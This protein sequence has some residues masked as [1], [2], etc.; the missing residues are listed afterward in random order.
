MKNTILRLILALASISCLFCSITSCAVRHRAGPAVP[1]GKSGS[2]MPPSRVDE[3]YRDYHRLELKAV[4][5]FNPPTPKDIVNNEVRNF[6]V[7]EHLEI[8]SIFGDKK[9]MHKG[10]VDAQDHFTAEFF[11]KE[12]PLKVKKLREVRFFMPGYKPRTFRDV[13]ISNSTIDLGTVSFEKDVSYVPRKEEYILA[14][15]AMLTFDPKVEPAYVCD[16]EHYGVPVKLYN[17]DKLDIEVEFDGKITHHPG[18][19]SNK[20]PS[21][22]GEPLIPV[23]ELAYLGFNYPVDRNPDK[24]GVIKRVRFSCPGYR[25]VVFRDVRI[26]LPH[27]VDFGVVKLVKK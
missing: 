1:A 9:T 10:F 15:R 8:Y 26:D 17:I 21:K 24:V 20:L 2:P 3:L 12:D 19:V 22:P 27:K 7:Y 25:D 16:N 11:V 14:I 6:F 18:I 4:F 13:P 23:D 5:V